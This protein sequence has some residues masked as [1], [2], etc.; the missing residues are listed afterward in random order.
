MRI[1]I[2]NWTSRPLGGVGSY[3]RLVMPALARR[4]HEVAFWHEGGERPDGDPFALPA[5]SPSWSVERIGLQ[6]ALDDLGAWRPDVLFSHGLSDPGVEARTLG[7]APAVF[8]VHGYHGTCISG[9]KTF[10]NPTPTPCSRRFGWPCLV[11]YYPRRCGGWSPVTMIREFGRQSERLRLLSRYKGLVAFSPHMR[12]EFARHG[13]PVTCLGPPMESGPASP[14]DGADRDG[15]DA[16]RLLFV[17]RMDP[18]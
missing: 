1:A 6:Q 18:L 11:N 13:I 5:G 10:K 3:L 16:W 7:I 14:G 15:G 2:L 8:H 12:D 9:A 4:G 17:G